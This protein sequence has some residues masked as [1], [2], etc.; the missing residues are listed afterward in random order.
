MSIKPCECGRMPELVR[1]DHD[2]VD[3]ES[4]VKYQVIC[5]E[6]GR[7]GPRCESKD[8]ARFFWNTERLN[9]GT[10]TRRRRPPGCSV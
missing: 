9:N 8:Y 6:C 3:F 4:M 5:P 10:K 1:E 2:E 7:S